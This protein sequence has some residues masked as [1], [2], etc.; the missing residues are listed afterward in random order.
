LKKNPGTQHLPVIAF[1]SETA[2]DLQSAALAA[3]V[4]LVVSETAI[5][6]HLSQCL[7]RVLQ[8]E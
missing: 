4:T 7:D 2:T 3:G 1:A 5:L 8:V 6:N